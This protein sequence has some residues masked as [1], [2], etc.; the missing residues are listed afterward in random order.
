[1][2]FVPPV[3]PSRRL[4][5]ATATCGA[6]AVSLLPASSAFAANGKTSASD[7]AAAQ[8]QVDA[9]NTAADKAVEAYDQAQAALDAAAAQA[10]AEQAAVARATAQVQVARAGVQALAAS[11]YEHGVDNSSLTYL[12]SGDSTSIGEK[13]ALLGAVNRA[14][15]ASL[16]KVIDAD[17]KLE[18]TQ[19]QATQALAAQQAAASALAARQVSVQKAL[20]AQ[21]AV[22]TTK[23]GQLAQEQAAAAAAQRLAAQQQAQLQASRS[24]ARTPVTTASVPNAR[25]GGAPVPAPAPVPASGGA[26]TAIAFAYAQLGKPYRFGGAGPGSYDCSGLTMRAWG[27]AGVS[28]AHSSSAQQHEGRPVSLSALQPGDLVFWGNPAY[29]VAIYIGGGRVIAAP[30][31]GTVVQIQA[32]WGRPSGAVRP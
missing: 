32:I 16:T 15:G 22:L 8:A 6:L 27:A 28:L 23:K 12:L 9:L 3:R 24:K 18:A 17:R 25:P 10:K 29:H 1:V 19:A 4:L 26:A 5:I 30:H 13:A 2:R 31:T 14:Q 11:E 21:Q 20:A 7:V